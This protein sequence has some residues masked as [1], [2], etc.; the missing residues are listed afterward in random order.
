MAHIDDATLIA[1]ARKAIERA[2]CP[3]S[4]FPVGAAILTEDGTIITGGNVENASYG[5]SICAERSAAVRAIA[6]GHRNFIAIAVV[7]ECKEPT[8]PCGFCRQFLM[9]FGDIKVIMA[10]GK[11][12]ERLSTTLGELLPQAFLPKALEDFT[13]G[14]QNKSNRE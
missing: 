2:Y 3:Y 14:N 6:E 4:K 8:P 10:S 1:A 5:G 13:A 11:T 7:T 12:D 9:E